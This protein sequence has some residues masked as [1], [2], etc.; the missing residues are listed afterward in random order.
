MSHHI[1]IV[2]DDPNIRNLIRQHLEQ[3]RYQV[4]EAENGIA[5]SHWLNENRADMAILD[6]VMPEMD[7]I[8]FAYELK[9]R[10]PDMPIL[11]ISAGEHIMSKE[12][13]LGMMECLGANEVL[14]KPFDIHTLMEAV[15]TLL[16][17]K[18]KV[19]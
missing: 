13:C 8:E 10:Y 9:R 3:D 19:A 15:K 1:L 6:V 16:K 2:D 5:A 17:K 18:H 4:S 14:S 11:A 7:G 12:L